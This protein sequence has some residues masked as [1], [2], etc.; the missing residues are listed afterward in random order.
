MSVEEGERHV[1][2][3][4]ACSPSSCTWKIS[5]KELLAGD[6]LCTIHAQNTR[7]LEKFKEWGI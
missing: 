3:G 2:D 5:L 4:G 1:M 7:K 6:A